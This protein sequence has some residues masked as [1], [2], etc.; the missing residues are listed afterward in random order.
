MYANIIPCIYNTCADLQSKCDISGTLSRQVMAITSEKKIMP[1]PAMRA[2]PPIGVIG[3][4][5][6]YLLGAQ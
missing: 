5:H 3:P 1:H 4:S 2:S 6:L